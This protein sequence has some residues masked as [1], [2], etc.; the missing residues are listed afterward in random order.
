MPDLLVPTE[1]LA[2][3]YGIPENAYA[4]LEY[5]NTLFNGR[6][7]LTGAPYITH[8]AELAILGKARG[9]DKVS[10][11]YDT[12]KYFDGQ[13]LAI[14]EAEGYGSDDDFFDGL[15]RLD[16]QHDSCELK[17]DPP[18]HLAVVQNA[19]LRPYEAGALS[20]IT[21]D[22]QHTYVEY[23][24]LLI[25]SRNIIA[26]AGKDGDLRSNKDVSPISDEEK[27]RSPKKGEKQDITWPESLR[28]IEEVLPVPKGR[29][30]DLAIAIST[31]RALR[32]EYARDYRAGFQEF[33]RQKEL[34]KRASED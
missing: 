20:V 11:N 30:T 8:L 5:A 7:R 26:I 27:K 24:G 10:E 6:Y 34:R 21:H 16:L 2:E 22:E 29:N 33:L 1:R 32:D 15:V 31:A 13:F 14:I 25:A 28:L 3:D 19:Q 23:R 17:E 12:Q 18:S 4:S 9:L